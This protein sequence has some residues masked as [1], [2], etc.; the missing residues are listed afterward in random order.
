[1]IEKIIHQI[2]IGNKRIPKHIKEWMQEIKEKHPE[3]TYYFWT[4]DNLP[5]MPKELFDIYV[6]A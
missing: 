6:N 2:W 3:F 4:D 1:M 5:E